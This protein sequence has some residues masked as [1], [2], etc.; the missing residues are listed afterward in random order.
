MSRL[1]Y[2]SVCIVCP[3][4]LH[5]K[6]VYGVLHAMPLHTV[7]CVSHISVCMGDNMCIAQDQH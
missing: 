1:L 2:D 7:Y 4:M 3:G 5:Y 6:C